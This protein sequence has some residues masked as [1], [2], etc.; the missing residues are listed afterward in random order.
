MAIPVIV[1]TPS[2][3]FGEL[4]QQVLQESGNYIVAVATNHDMALQVTEDIKPVLCIMDADLDEGPLDE[5]FAEMQAK[6]SDL[7]LLLVP[8]EDSSD[9]EKLGELPI[10]GFLSKPFY[11][12]DLLATVE[13]VI[14]KSDIKILNHLPTQP[15]EADQE[16]T[17]SNIPPA[18]DWLKDVTLA[19][20]HLTR[21][22]LSSAS[23][24]A[25][26]TRGEDLWAYAGELPQPAAE[27]LAH[28]TAHYWTDAGG[29]DMARY[30]RLE[31]TGGEY[32]LYATS[33][34]GDFILALAFDA[35]TPFSDI[36]SQ[37]NKLA[38]A[39][40]SPPEELSA[41]TKPGII[42]EPDAIQWEVDP[43]PDVDYSVP[44][45]DDVPPS[46]PEDWIPQSTPSEDRKDFLDDLFADNTMPDP[47][48][49]SKD[50]QLATFDPPVSLK[51]D[52]QSSD[53]ETLPSTVVPEEEY[54]QQ[55]FQAET[56]PSQAELSSDPIADTIPSKKDKSEEEPL[57]VEPISPAMYNLTY[58]CVLL[59]RFPQHHLTGDLTTKLSE[60]IT[61]LCIAFGWRMEH[62]SIRPDYLHWM[63]NVPPTTSPGY[64]IRI[65][66]QHTSRR[67]F[68]DFS[69]ME[70]ENP[71]GDFWAPGYLIISGDQQPPPKLIKNFIQQTRE[72][73][74]LSS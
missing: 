8:P 10:A 18:P 65:V 17:P 29:G 37:A 59:P 16:K 54:D 31:T 7:L 67:I 33:L 74:G 63:V 20:Q 48:P 52:E 38:R 36:R 39:I 47:M 46:I 21:L 6:V 51:L 55:D 41:D 27:E 40:A 11:L 53:I 56:L 14:K 42:Q 3:G 62:I 34:G 5:L 58:T 66:R 24:A 50:S 23:Q 1:L 13:K 4:I 45:L 64:I 32:M 72:R 57:T 30:A 2:K 68:L 71:S 44:L 19:A 22:S 35:E 61:Q 69:R 25:L 43:D 73:Q 28:T 49:E 9:R 15:D 70:E 26:I 60:W 12:P